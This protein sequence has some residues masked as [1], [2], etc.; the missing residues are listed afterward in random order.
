MKQIYSKNQVKNPR[1]NKEVLERSLKE[2]KAWYQK[3]LS[4]RSEANLHHEPS[5]LSVLFY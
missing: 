3:I 2:E 1:E 5:T 4:D